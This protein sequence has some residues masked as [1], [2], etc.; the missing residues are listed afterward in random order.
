MTEILYFVGLRLVLIFF[1]INKLLTDQNDYKIW[2]MIKCDIQE[3]PNYFNCD[4]VKYCDL[5][6]NV[7]SNS[8][9]IKK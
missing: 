5:N 9:I 6:F 2:G 1:N 3:V 4:N 7:A 8:N